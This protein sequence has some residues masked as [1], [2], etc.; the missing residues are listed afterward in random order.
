MNRKLIAL[1]AVAVIALSGCGGDDTDAAADP[2]TSAEASATEASE[3]PSPSAEPSPTEEPVPT[4]DTPDDAA[5]GSDVE[6]C[7]D[8]TC[9][10]AVAPGT[11]LTFDAKFGIDSIEV[12]EIADD[13]VTLHL[14]LGMT[15]MTTLGVGGSGS[16]GG[17]E[18]TESLGYT[19]TSVDGDS[20]IIAFYPREREDR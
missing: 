17:G 11:S 20:A 14:S 4:D 2:T 3:S 18:G 7:V 13:T 6:A 9:E 10:V 8:G 15:S 16:A 1:P 5:D 19:L 12:V